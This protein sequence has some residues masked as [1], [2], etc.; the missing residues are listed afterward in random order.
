MIPGAR[1]K[2]FGLILKGSSHPGEV[3]VRHCCKTRGYNH[4]NDVQFAPKL[5]E[6]RLSWICHCAAQPINCF[7]NTSGN[8]ATG[9]GLPCGEARGGLGGSDG[10]PGTGGDGRYCGGGSGNRLGTDGGYSQLDGVR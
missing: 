9:I 2:G 5:Y 10:L 6:T 1:F 8:G 7:E 4:D 3:H